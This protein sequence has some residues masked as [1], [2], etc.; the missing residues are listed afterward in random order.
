ML[1]ELQREVLKEGGLSG[2]QRGKL[3]TALAL[4]DKAL[5]DGADEF[6]QLLQVASVAGRVLSVGA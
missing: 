4:A 6:L 5:V 3:C 2:P 1:V